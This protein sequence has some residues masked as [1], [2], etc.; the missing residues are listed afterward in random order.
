[1]G[2]LIQKQTVKKELKRLLFCTAGALLYAFNLQS[3]V[4]TGGLFP[5]GFAGITL[6]IQQISEEYLG[7]SLAYTL[8]YIPLNLIPI[9]I[10]IKYLGK[11]FTF[12]SIYVIVLS[13]FMTDIIPDV[14]ITYDVLLICI[15][16]GILNHCIFTLRFA[17]RFLLIRL[18]EDTFDVVEL[19]PKEPHPNVRDGV[20]VL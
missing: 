18:T 3:F 8:V 11:R 1:M 9:Y 15:F 19:W 6:L 17:T 7:I 2:R 16:G 13:S 14:T 20:L 10:G 5:G 12:Y 4:R